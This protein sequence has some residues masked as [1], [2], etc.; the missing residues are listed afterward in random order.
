M[1]TLAV[2]TPS[3]NSEANFIIIASS[4]ATGSLLLIV[5]LGIIIFG[6]LCIAVTLKQKK[7]KGTES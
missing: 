7:K 1:I 2:H 5:F 6:S 3:L 4:V